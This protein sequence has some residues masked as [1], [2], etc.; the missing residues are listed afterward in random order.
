MVIQNITLFCADSV[1]SDINDI[2]LNLKNAF[3]EV[4][5]FVQHYATAVCSQILINIVI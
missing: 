1:I 4:C 5:L 2:N 3:L